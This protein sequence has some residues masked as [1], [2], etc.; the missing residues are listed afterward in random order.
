[1]SIKVTEFP[2]LNSK[3]NSRSPEFLENLEKWKPITEQLD[4]ALETSASQ[5]QIKGQE[6]HISRG[7]LLGKLSK[8]SAT[9]PDKALTQCQARDRVSLLLDPGSP[10]LE[11]CALAGLDDKDSSPS[12]SIVSGIGLV[13]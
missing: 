6:R 9:V 11:L 13:K 7:Q 1:M 4:Q 3:I 12:A 5:G 8:Q 10:F 2:V